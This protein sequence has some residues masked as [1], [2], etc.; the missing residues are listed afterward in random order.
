MAS[1]ILHIKDSY[2]F[3]V[4]KSFWR[5]DF[6]SASQINGSFPWFARLD[7]DYQDWEAD[8]FIEKLKGIVD[9]PSVLAGLKQQWEQAKH[10]HANHG[11]PLDQ[12]LVDS[13]ADLESRAKVW[14]S[15]YEPTAKSA[16]DAYVAKFPE[17][18]FAWVAML[19][20][21]KGKKAQWEQFSKEADSKEAFSEYLALDR[22]K[23]DSHKLASYSD[24]LSGKVFIPQIFG[25]Q[26]RNAYDRESGICISKFMIIELAVALLVFFAFRWLAGK[27]HNGEAPKGKLWNLLEGAVQFVRNQVVVPA[28]GDDHSA[29]RFLPLFLTIFFFILG[30]NLAGM[31]PFLGAPTASFS[32]TLVL[33][34]VIFATSL[35]FGIKELGAVG[36]FANMA[37]HVDLPFGLGKVI[38]LLV[39]VIE[40]LSLLIKH[41]VLA[42]RLLANMVAGHLVLLAIMGIA[43]GLHAASMNFGTWSIVAVVSILGTT[44]LSFLE[45]F[46]CF[47]QAYVFTFLAALFIGSATHHHH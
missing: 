19:L 18:K 34:G 31:I 38:S 36:F 5:R 8:R 11:K 13:A 4:P 23:W 41:L 47:L 14:R 43:F 25:G 37:P 2:Y 12:F 33:A 44:A 28:M 21:D 10:S 15:K 45:L 20:R 27:M 3:D 7:S 17:E 22:S 26:L 1:D 6:E 42:V 9:D 30:C 35:I 16:L 40:T 29:D 32:T 24:A 46:V 39:L